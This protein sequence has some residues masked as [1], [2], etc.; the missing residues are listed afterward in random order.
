MS[1]N[2]KRFLFFIG[3]YFV[4]FSVLGFNNYSKYGLFAPP[5]K[6]LDNFGAGLSV[7]LVV[8]VTWFTD[9]RLLEKYGKSSAAQPIPEPV[10]SEMEIV[11]NNTKL[12]Q[13]DGKA[14]DSNPESYSKRALIEGLFVFSV[15]VIGLLYSLWTITW[16]A[17]Q[18]P[19]NWR[20]ATV[21]PLDLF[22]FGVWLL[23]PISV[24]GTRHAWDNLRFKRTG[25]GIIAILLCTSLIWFA[26]PATA[27]TMAQ[28]NT[29]RAEL[30]RRVND[31]NR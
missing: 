19:P 21:S 22:A 2:L 4:I 26:I 11:S 17:G 12:M 3:I 31:Y 10:S 8:A 29:Q 14:E 18:N 6:L 20:P 5:S 7:L 27:I 30:K 9:S 25:A 23:L 1:R 15:L 28:F 24:L 16:I 13:N